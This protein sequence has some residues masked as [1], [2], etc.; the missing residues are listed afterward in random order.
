MVKEAWIACGMMALWGLGCDGLFVEIPDRPDPGFAGERKT[1]ERCGPCGRFLIQEGGA[2]QLEGLEFTKEDDACETLGF[3]NAAASEQGNGSEE[4]PWN[5]LPQTLPASLKALLVADE[6]PLASPLDLKGTLEI[7][8]GWS[9]KGGRFVRGEGRSSLVVE[10]NKPEQVC[11]ALTLRAPARVTRMRVETIGQAYGHTTARVLEAGG[12]T[13]DDV[14]LVAADGA[15]PRVPNPGDQGKTGEPGAPGRTP[16]GGKG[17]ASSCDA[18][19]GGTGGIGGLSKGGDRQAERGETASG[20][21]GGGIGLPGEN[22]VAGRSGQHAELP[23]APTFFFDAAGEWIFAQGQ[24]GDRGAPG[25]PGGGGGGGEPGGDGE[26]G[27]GG[28]GGL[29]G[30]GGTGGAPGRS[31]G[32]SVALALWA[33]KVSILGGR[34]VSGDGG[35]GSAGGVGGAGGAGGMGGQGGPPSGTGEPGARGGMGGQGGMGGMGAPGLGG[36]SVAVLCQGASSLDLR[37]DP[38]FHHGRAGS[39]GGG[40]GEA[41]AAGRL[42]CP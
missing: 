11:T 40:Q 14:E 38:K 41:Q 8:G 27:G 5:V 23:S 20:A 33:S 2:C 29:G 4:S 42:G 32:P 39:H 25:M 35:A 28:Q 13:F 6:E 9:V 15:M 36:L 1:G 17:A 24:A 7:S 22:G 26:G 10:C 21:L 18:A 31:G 30:C 19:L 37:D 3:V 16:E 34:F 12:V